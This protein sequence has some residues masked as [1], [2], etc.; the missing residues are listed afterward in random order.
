[1]VADSAGI[2]YIGDQYN[3]RVRAV[4]PD[5]VIHTVA[6]M[7]KVGYVGDHDSPALEA[8]LISPDILCINP[9]GDIYIPDYANH[10]VRKLSRTK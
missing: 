5:G 1:V 8:R 7:G 4:T 9:A 2:V 3:R 10:A 6:G